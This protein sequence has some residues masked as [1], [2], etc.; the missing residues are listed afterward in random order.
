M[1][2]AINRVTNISILWL[3]NQ[4]QHILILH[5]FEGIGNSR[6]P[7]IS[8][9]NFRFFETWCHFE[10]WLFQ[11]LLAWKPPRL[12]SDGGQGLNFLRPMPRGSYPF[13]VG[14]CFM[15]FLFYCKKIFSI[16]FGRFS[17]PWVSCFSAF[18][19][20]WFFRFTKVMAQLLLKVYTVSTSMYM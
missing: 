4:K 12:P 10:K 2:P 3:R 16:N 8:L 14:S 17:P 15:C 6:N 1:K 9:K 13:H 11:I 18:S 19:S 7:L 5:H 20:K